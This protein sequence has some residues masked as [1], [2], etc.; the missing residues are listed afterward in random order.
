MTW[1]KYVAYFIH[2]KL[3]YFDYL[4]FQLNRLAFLILQYMKIAPIHLWSNENCVFQ[5]KTNG[6]KSARHSVSSRASKSKLNKC[7]ANLKIVILKSIYFPMGFLTSESEEYKR[8]IGQGKW[9]W[10][11][12]MCECECVFVN[13]FDSSSTH[14]HHKSLWWQ[15]IISIW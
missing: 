15:H 9:R 11:C 4:K 3:E 6:K 12:L 5:R 13:E 8:A 2:L 7:S 14:S 10:H 1:T